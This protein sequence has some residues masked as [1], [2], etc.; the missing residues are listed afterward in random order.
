MYYFEMYEQWITVRR[1]REKIAD[2]IQAIQ[3]I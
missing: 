3:I 1:F 2:T